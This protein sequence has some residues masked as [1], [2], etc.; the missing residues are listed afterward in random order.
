MHAHLT[1]C[2]NLYMNLIFI[3]NYIYKYYSY[4]HSYSVCPNSIEIIEIIE[5]P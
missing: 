4:S 3:Y 5:M 1:V 2:D